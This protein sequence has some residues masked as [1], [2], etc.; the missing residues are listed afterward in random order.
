MNLRAGILLSAL[1]TINAGCSIQRAVVAN[2]AQEKM[3]GFTK[4]QVL[5]CMGPPGARAVEG[6]TEVWSYGS[7]DGRTTTV[8][9]GVAQADATAYGG[10]GYA[11]GTATGSSI[12]TATSTR[13]FCTVNVTMR[14]GR[15][16]RINYSGPTG[17]LLTPGEQ[18][19]FAV[20][21]CT[22]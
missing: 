6:A 21:N 11:S 3:V 13:R 10:P 17:G 22:R 2:Q 5:G 16:S 4:E 9:S 20:Q 19:A 1:A 15:V 8:A 12:G 7:G 18:C 14:D